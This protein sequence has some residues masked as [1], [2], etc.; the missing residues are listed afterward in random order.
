LNRE[1]F[2]KYDEYAQDLEEFE[3]RYEYEDEYDD[4]YDSNTNAYDEGQSEY[5]I[6]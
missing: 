4:T 5:F 3:R 2:K 1:F 6:K